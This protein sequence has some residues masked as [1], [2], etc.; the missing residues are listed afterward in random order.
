MA[1]EACVRRLLVLLSAKIDQKACDKCVVVFQVA[2]MATEVCV[3]RLRQ[4]PISG[5]TDPP[6]KVYKS[7]K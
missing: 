4:F 3:R 1:T 7:P 6:P 2:K 5:P